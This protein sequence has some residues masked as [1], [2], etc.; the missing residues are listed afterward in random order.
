MT[1]KQAEYYKDADELLQA[2]RK[3]MQPDNVN[4]WHECR[5]IVKQHLAVC[6][7]R[8]QHATIAGMS[9]MG[10]LNTENIEIERGDNNGVE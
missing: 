1:D 6:Q 5:E 2:L 9:A 10:L 8:A 7:I 3:Y 4:D